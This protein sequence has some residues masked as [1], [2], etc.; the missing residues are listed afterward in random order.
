[1][2]ATS[3]ADKLCAVNGMIS[4]SVVTTLFNGEEYAERMIDS[5]LPYLF[6]TDEWIVVDDGSTD[7]GP[8]LFASAFSGHSNCRLI[9]QSNQGMVAAFNVCLQSAT[10]DYLLNIDSGD[11]LTNDG[12]HTIRS[13]L[14]LYHPDILHFG[15]R[16][17][18]PNGVDIERLNFPFDMFFESKQSA[19]SQPSFT[20]HIK[21]I[22]CSHT[23]QA[24]KRAT[25]GSLLL[26]EPAAGSDNPFMDVIFNNANS[27]A[28]TRKVCYV[29]YLTEGSI[30]RRSLPPEYYGQ[31]LQRL[32]RI[33]PILAKSDSANYPLYEA[34][35]V[36]FAYRDW[37]ITTSKTA[38]F[39]RALNKLA[40][41]LIRKHRR[42][43]LP[44]TRPLER[45][46]NNIVIVWPALA[47]A[48]WK[49][50]H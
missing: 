29:S 8:S 49:H 9:R 28:I 12:L 10:K 19:L 48:L 44:R 3:E 5:V 38:F 4:I 17:L 35:D 45:A 50:I 18:F 20:S 11:Y 26:E 22:L 41:S 42:M 2:R 33:V 6:P 40:L 31:A 24:I 21:C 14:N 7:N 23:R 30:S 37:Y 34:S 32:L 39:D 46:F 15:Y 13:L 43:C 25:I 16:E 47:A 27:F 1:M 36:F